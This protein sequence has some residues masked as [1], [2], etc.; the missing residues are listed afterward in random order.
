MTP[1]KKGLLMGRSVPL[2]CQWNDSGGF[3]LVAA[4]RKVT[5]R[6]DSASGSL[7]TYIQML[8]G[9]WVMVAGM[10]TVSNAFSLSTLPPAPS[11]TTR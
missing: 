7:G 6:F 4:M 3:R 2:T 9:C 10:V 5:A 11:T 1:K 8:V